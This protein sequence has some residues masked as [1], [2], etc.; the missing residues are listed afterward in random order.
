VTKSTVPETGT[1][2]IVLGLDTSSY[3]TSLCAISLQFGNILADIR[4]VLPVD[5]GQIGLRQSQAAFLHQRQLPELMF[6]LQATFRS[7]CIHT[8]VVRCIGVSVRPRPLMTSYMPVFQA[9]ASL[10]HS[11]ANF[12]ER[13]PVVHTTHQE[14]HLAAADFFLPSAEEQSF[15]AVHLSGG[16]SDVL[17][18]TW[19]RFGYRIEEIGLGT[20]LHAGQFVDRVGVALGLPFPAGPQMER[21]AL[22][23]IPGQEGTFHLPTS[24]SGTSMSFSGPC[25]A[26]MRAIKNGIAPPVIAHAVMRSIATAVIKAIHSG[27]QHQMVD[28]VVIAGGV[29]SNRWIRDR[30]V[31]RLAILH[32]RLNVQFA[33]PRYSSDNALG[34]AAIARKFILS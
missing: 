15:L 14:G 9:G 31:H 27:L 24:V 6:E 5:S 22:S 19:T 16:T 8:P 1:V 29:S 25:S 32:P 12:L 34:V 20:D 10:A 21:L 18:A 11:L 17:L 23:V 30:I 7:L 26:A 33:P 28:R 13:I 3:T 4:R 2:D